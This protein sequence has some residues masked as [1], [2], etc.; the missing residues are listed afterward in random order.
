[1]DPLEIE[2]TSFIAGDTVSWTKSLSDYSAAEGWVLTYEFR[3]SV[4]K[5]VV[6]TA[7]A[8]AHLATISAITSATFAPGVYYVTAF[9]T[10]ATERY[11]VYQG[12][13]QVQPNPA[14]GTSSFDGRSHA[15]RCL[16]AIE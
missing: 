3:G 13:I 14:V 1:M 12:R 8:A 15:R 9:V 11:T 6:C 4:R 7:D 2:P 5:T 10:K 16:E